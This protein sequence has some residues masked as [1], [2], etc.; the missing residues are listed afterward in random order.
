MSFLSTK[1]PQSCHP[2]AKNATEFADSPTENGA[3]IIDSGDP[4]C[5]YQKE[6]QGA[7]ALSKA[8]QQ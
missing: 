2:A 3:A 1:A 5:A 4:I 7:D 8:P 6:T